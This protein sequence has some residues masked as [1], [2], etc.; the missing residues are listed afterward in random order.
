MNLVE[1]YS[2]LVIFIVSG[3]LVFLLTFLLLSF[4][5]AVPYLFRFSIQYF[6][7]PFLANL[8]ILKPLKTTEN[9]VFRGYKMGTLTR[10]GLIW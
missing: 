3:R 9:G 2:F 10:N 5:L 7:N 1:T 8:P 4:N 6:F